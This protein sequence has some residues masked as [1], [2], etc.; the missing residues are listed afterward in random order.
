MLKRWRNSAQ[1]SFKTVWQYFR[2]SDQEF[3]FRRVLKLS[4]N[5]FVE[6]MREF[7]W[8][9]YWDCLRFFSLK[10][11]GILVETSFEIVWQ[12]FRWSDEEIRL[13]RVLKLSY[14][15][16]VEAMREFGWDKYWVGLR[17]YLLKRWGRL[18]QT[19]FETVLQYFRWGDEDIRLRRVLK[20]Y[21]NVFVE[22]LRQFGW[23]KFWDRLRIFSLK[24]W[25]NS[26]ETSFEIV[27]QYFRWNDAEI[28]LRRVLKVSYKVFVEAMREFGSDKYW[29]GLRI[30]F[31][32]RWGRLAQTSFE[33]VLQYFR[34][35]NEEFRLRRVLKLSYNVFVETMREFG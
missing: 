3:R 34:W 12:Y 16:F 14:N 7:G 30:Y 6:A 21:Y 32:K 31:L 19:S 1:T 5:V 13:R 17:I 20:M 23:Y 9:K 4:Y 24:R 11:W 26:G 33:N 28:R 8:D 35:S 29:V 27:W 2:W 15:V 10:Q 22:A 18:A 25:G